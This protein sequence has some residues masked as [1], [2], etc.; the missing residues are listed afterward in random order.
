MMT[1]DHLLFWAT[2]RTLR[3]HR[4]IDMQ[5]VCTWCQHPFPSISTTDVKSGFRK[6][7]P[8]KTLIMEAVR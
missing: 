2:P 3:F 5:A 1:A 6:F 4:I 8:D 7:L